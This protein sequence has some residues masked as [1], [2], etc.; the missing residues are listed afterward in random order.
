MLCERPLRLK[1][2]TVTKSKTG[3]GTATR[4]SGHWCPAPH[5]ADARW[6]PTNGTRSPSNKGVMPL[7]S[8]I[9]H[10]PFRS[11]HDL[12][13]PHNDILAVIARVYALRAAK[14]DASIW[15]C[16]PPHVHCLKSLV[17]FSTWHQC[18]HGGCWG[19]LTPSLFANP[20]PFLR[21][22]CSCEFDV[23][24]FGIACLVKNRSQRFFAHG[25]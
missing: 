14:K 5:R 25:F 23:H 24:F 20:M 6:K 22:H 13:L 4:I 11:L 8:Q 19:T 21:M 7:V 10:P 16:R 18:L 2:W 9:L 17:F 15:V 12:Y 3:T 1:L